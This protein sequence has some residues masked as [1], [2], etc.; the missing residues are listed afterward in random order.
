FGRHDDAF[1]A[2]FRHAENIAPLPAVKPKPRGETI[3]L[4]KPDLAQLAASDPSLAATMEARRTIYDY[5]ARPIT[6]AQIGELLYR[7]ARVR[8]TMEMPVPGH[9]ALTMPV[10]SR[11][12]PSGGKSYEIE[13]YLTI[14][15]CDGIAPGLYHY[16]A[17]DHQ[18]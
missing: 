14:N 3:E 17:R 13:F 4:P 6:I 18:L 8:A 7:V 12:Y 15:A 1:G 10:S 9:D 2:T 16:D 11:P 5:A